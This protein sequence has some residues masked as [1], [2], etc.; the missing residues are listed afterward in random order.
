[1]TTSVL[2]CPGSNNIIIEQWHRSQQKFWVATKAAPSQNSSPGGGPLLGRVYHG[3]G[4]PPPSG[5][6]KAVDGPPRA[7]CGRVARTVKHHNVS[8]DMPR[9][10]YVCSAQCCAWAMTQP[11]VVG[12]VDSNWNCIDATPVTRIDVQ[13][14]WGKGVLMLFKGTRGWPDWLL[15]SCHARAS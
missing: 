6:I 4:A 13:R 2:R 9:A 7:R 8:W 11:P 10:R 5:E 1:M 3:V 12:Y 15:S 14:G